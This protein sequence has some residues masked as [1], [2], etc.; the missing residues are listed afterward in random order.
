MSQS[1]W[2][3][4]TIG[5]RYEIQSLLGQ[6]GMSAVYKANDP[7]L[8]RVVAIKLIH[9]HLSNNP[10]FVRR[11]EEEAAAVAR[12]RHPNIIQVFDFNHDQDV[13]YIVFEFVAGESL[14]QYQSRLV[15]AG[16]TM[17][18]TQTVEL[19]ASVADAL[20]YAHARD[21]IHRDIKPAN[22]MLNVQ[23]EAILMDFGLVKIAGGD[24][25]TATG[26]VMGTASYM[27]PEQIRGE[28]VDE[29][30]DIYSLGIM[31]F[32][33]AAGRPPFK[34][35]SALTLMMMHVNDPVP[36]LQEIRPEVPPALVQ[37]IDEALAKDRADRF[38]S[39]EEFAL[40]LRSAILSDAGAIA[41]KAAIVAIASAAIAA[42]APTATGPGSTVAQ[43]PASPQPPPRPQAAQAP[44]P[45]MPSQAAAA[46]GKSSKRNI[47]IIGAV[48][49]AL[50]LLL[51]IA[52]AVIIFGSGLLSGD[53][54]N[55]DAGNE[56]QVA[57]VEETRDEAATEEST[58]SE[59][60]E[61]AAVT[62]PT[63]T[64]PAATLIPTKE[65]T[66]EPTEEV[67]LQSILVPTLRPTEEPTLEP[68]LA[69]TIQP[70]PTTAAS[71][72]SPAFKSAQITNITIANGQYVVDYVTYGYTPSLP[73]GEHVHFFFDTV[74]VLDAGVPGAGPWILY[75]GPVPFT[76]YP[77]NARPAGASEMCSLVANPDHSIQPGTGNCFALP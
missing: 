27:S 47:G 41:P 74:G 12:L 6:G 77:V 5:G 31:L 29:R 65:P 56:T 8:K 49:V 63:K 10:E 68:T 33:M 17:A 50:L 55:Q 34:A 1:N 2:I 35:D 72:T 7:N 48:A 40:A 24:S 44:V 3:G 4:K 30:T 38:A 57:M 69:P 11:F 67:T 59:T 20:A 61:A 75:A 22:V 62:D 52:S 23:N 39:A 9:P 46:S 14:Q 19:G 53:D 66:E 51:C 71:P 45:P 21:I 26:A 13:F 73:G 28:R 32:E 16:R 76:G 42:S 15:E 37:V 70:S 36:D 18:L 43:P 64:I 60:E 54:N 58:A 25:H